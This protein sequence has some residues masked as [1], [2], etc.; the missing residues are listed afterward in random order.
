[1]LTGQ[2]LFVTGDMTKIQ[3]VL[4]NLIDNATKF[5]HNNSAIKI[6]TSIKNEKVLISVKDSGIGIP[7][8]SIKKFGIVSTKQISPAE[9]I[10]RE[11]VLDSQL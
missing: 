2:E 3:Q 1:M 8:D 4:Y 11:L 6:E 10:R 9:K 7:A 5:S